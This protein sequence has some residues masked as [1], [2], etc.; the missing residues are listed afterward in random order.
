V[1]IGAHIKQLLE[2]RNRVILPGFGNLEI[3]EPGTGFPVSGKKID[4]PGLSIRFDSSYSKDDGLLSSVLSKGEQL[5]KE[6]AEQQVLEL[7]DAIKFALDKGEPYELAGAGTFRRDDDGKVHFQP[8]TGWMLEPDQ[9]GLEPMDL[10][11]LE[12]LPAE[13]EV[14]AASQEEEKEPAVA[15][16]AQKADQREAPRPKE[17]EK[18]KESE[19]PKEP[20]GYRPT[21]PAVPMHE[22]WKEEKPPRRFRGWRVIWLVA[23]LLIVVLVVLILV[24]AERFTFSRTQGETEQPAPGQK[25]VIQQGPMETEAA[26]APAAGTETPAAV[27]RETTNRQEDVQSSR[28]PAEVH[29]FYIIAGSFKHL[30]NA[31]ELQDRLKARGY[32]AEVMMTENRMYRVSVASYATK[33]EAERALAGLKSDPGLASCWLL[34][35]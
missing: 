6:E 10:L 7:V 25:P 9:Y 4:P 33:R 17:P 18:P 12:D 5:D 19:K 14:P 27:D 21:K 24:P 20:I 23:A 1:T 16:T 26:E 8:E 30:G 35:N 15:E 3:K 32:P 11:E 29:N 2:E 34:S 13:E 22:P 31:S 28:E